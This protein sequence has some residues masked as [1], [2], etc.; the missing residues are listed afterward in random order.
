MPLIV[1]VPIIL[2][3]L[4]LTEGAASRTPTDVQVVN[5]PV[6]AAGNLRVSEQGA[7]QPGVQEIVMRFLESDRPSRAYS[8]EIQLPA[9]FSKVSI[10]FTSLSGQARVTTYVLEFGSP[11]G[12]PYGTLWFPS[13]PIEQGFYSPQGLPAVPP[14]LHFAYFIGGGALRIS[15]EAHDPV[16]GSIV[17][18]P[19]SEY[20]VTVFLAR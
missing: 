11:V 18:P 20:L 16:T 1:G 9:G 2:A 4:T 7:V 12:P 10:A 17:V 3:A 6:D 14:N 13:F 5:F 15:F 19:D 8:P